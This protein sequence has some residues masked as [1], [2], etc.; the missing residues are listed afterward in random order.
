MPWNHLEPLQ[1]VLSVIR[2]ELNDI[3]LGEQTAIPS[4]TYALYLRDAAYTISEL[5]AAAEVRTHPPCSHLF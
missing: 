1:M 3:L 4:A 5:I 2:G